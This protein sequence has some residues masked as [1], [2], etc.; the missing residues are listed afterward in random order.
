MTDEFVFYEIGV[1]SILVMDNCRVTYG[2]LLRRNY[3]LVK[4]KFFQKC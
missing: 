3:H 4:E 2:E 1:Y